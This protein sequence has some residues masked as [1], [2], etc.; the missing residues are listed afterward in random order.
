MKYFYRGEQMKKKI[1]LVLVASI[2][3]G[4][5]VAVGCAA[6]SPAP[7]PSPAPT[8]APT[9]APEEVFTWRIQDIGG[10][11][12]SSQYI[13]CKQLKRLIE[14]GSGGQVQVEYFSAGVLVDPDAVVDAVAMG[15][16]E[17]GNIIT[18]MAA[19]R[20]P[21]S[22]SSEM[23]FGARDRYQHHEVHHLWGIQDIVREELAEQNLYL[24][25][26]SYAGTIAFQS[27]FPV[28][29]V[30]DFEGKKIWCTPNT[31]WLTKFGAAST[32]VPGFDMYMAVKLG[33]I[34]GFVW[35]V[36]E[37]EYFNFKEVVNYVM[38]PSLLVPAM[39][40]LVNMDA[41]NALGPDL[42]RQIQDHI[43]TYIFEAITEE[44]VR[45]D[46]TSLAAAEDYGVQFITLTP[47]EAAKLMAAADDF[48]DEVAG[49]SPYAAEM[50]E[51]YRDWLE[52]RGLAW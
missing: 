8:P 39:Q 43:D 14:E 28:N 3:I 19:D 49:M 15:A 40:L 26:I 35:T 18:G 9:P 22:L 33:T 41:W 48:W 21:S 50:I 31:L 37:L 51:S 7:P 34:D 52:Y 46:T 5:L 4:S 27:T 24:L 25:A 12:D 30:D 47:A 32:D 38:W 44:F 6:P 2:L 13:I 10:E 36:A 11:A 1:L 45:Y 16:I 17:G 20:A 42:Q 29:A 23:P